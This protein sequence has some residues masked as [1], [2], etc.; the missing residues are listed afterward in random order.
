MTLPRSFRRQGIVLES[1]PVGEADLLVTL[2][3]SETGKVWA[4]ARGARKPTSKL[5][6]HLEP[7]TLVEVSFTRGPDLHYVSQAQALDS[8]LPLKAKL[9]GVARGLYLAE[10]AS[11]YG[12][13]DVPTPTL[14]ALLLESLRLLPCC[15]SPDV[16]LRC[17]E[18]Q[19]LRAAGFMPELY[20]CV[21]C[22]QELR[23][24]GHQF[25]PESGGVLCDR[26]RPVGVLVRPLSLEGLKVLRFLANT[27]LAEA[28]RLRLEGPL[29]DE[30]SR[31]LSMLLSYWPAHEMRSRSFMDQLQAS[32]G[33]APRASR[34]S[35]GSEA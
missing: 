1:K 16:L 10:L 12:M 15:K 17:F 8:F 30:V 27:T 2:L 32:S 26:C 14:Y 28:D 25:S 33:T 5:V 22:G 3:S 6:G 35:A 4:V 19:L 34:V 24:M 23:P 13:A 7:L 11:W 21:D 20:R 29:A 9:G 18:L 31:L